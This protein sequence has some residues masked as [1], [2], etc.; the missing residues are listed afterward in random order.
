MKAA[1]PALTVETVYVPDKPKH[2]RWE[3]IVP[4]VMGCGPNPMA[5]MLD[6]ANKLDKEY[7]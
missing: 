6:L 3:A 2:R 7:P 5:A 1:Q 4:N